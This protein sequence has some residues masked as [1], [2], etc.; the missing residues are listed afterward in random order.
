MARLQVENGRSCSAGLDL[1][2]FLTSR[3]WP[4]VNFGG[5]LPLYF[6][7]SAL[8]PSALKLRIT[9]R[10]RSSLVTAAPA[11]DPHQPLPLVIIDLAHPQ[12]F[13]HRA[14]LGDQHLRGKAWPAAPGLPRR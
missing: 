12:P 4:S 10:T 6:G 2:V 1:A 8:N 9:S 3:R 14:S 7:Y 5:R 11:H 13:R